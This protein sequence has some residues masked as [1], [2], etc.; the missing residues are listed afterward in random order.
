MSTESGYPSADTNSMLADELS[1]GAQMA[2][3]STEEP[4]AD[5][6]DI[7]EVNPTPPESSFATGEEDEGI[8]TPTTSKG[9]GKMQEERVVRK[10]LKLLDL[11]M[12]ILKEIVK[13][14]VSLCLLDPTMVARHR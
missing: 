4:T 7:D 8:T 14:V 9:K 10:P 2:L 5:F 3:F 12:D 1:T 13:E 11:P 6:D